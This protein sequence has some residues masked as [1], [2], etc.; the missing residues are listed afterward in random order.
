M[1]D[2]SLKADGSVERWIELNSEVSFQW[3]FCWAISMSTAQSNQPVIII[4]RQMLILIGN[5][6][7]IMRF[8]IS[9][10]YSFN[11]NISA[12]TADIDWCFSGYFFN[13]VETRLLS[14]IKVLGQKK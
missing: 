4:F 7:E 13:R 12:F 1:F 10:P 6:K 11:I 9:F 3:Y 8:E 2:C 14:T 5:H